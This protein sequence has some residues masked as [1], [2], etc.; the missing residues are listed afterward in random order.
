MSQDLKFDY[1]YGVLAVVA[2]MSEE[3]FRGTSLEA[4][5]R[6][7]ETNHFLASNWDLLRT[8]TYLR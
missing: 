6:I 5:S 1:G 7:R 4:R 3:I 8:T 2:V